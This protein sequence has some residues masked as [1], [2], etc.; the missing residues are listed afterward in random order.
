MTGL[1]PT[2]VIRNSLRDLTIK[3]LRLEQF[4]RLLRRFKVTNKMS[5]LPIIIVLSVF[6]VQCS[7]CYGRGELV[8][9]LI[10]DIIRGERSPAVI[11]AKVCWPKSEQIAFVKE[12][13]FM[14]QFVK[15]SADLRKISAN[16]INKVYFF[17]DMNCSEG[18][19][20]LA[21]VDEKVFSHPYR[22]ILTNENVEN[23]SSFPFLPDSNVMV[24]D[25]LGNDSFELTQGI[26][27]V[28][29]LTNSMEICSDEIRSL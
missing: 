28:I 21:S 22:W 24:A 23:L 8:G 12:L 3:G 17:A 2:T 7:H 4:F 1:Q 11:S 27:L 5:V 19:S 20:F 25:E 16:E 26:K 13:P 6:S 29:L 14:I 15:T 18:R 9:K 10:R